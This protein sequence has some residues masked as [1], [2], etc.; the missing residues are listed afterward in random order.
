MSD[1]AIEALCDIITKL[2]EENEDLRNQISYLEAR[3][4][5]DQTRNI[6]QVNPCPCPTPPFVITC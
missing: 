2:R 5:A 6:V 3:R 4:L 1:R